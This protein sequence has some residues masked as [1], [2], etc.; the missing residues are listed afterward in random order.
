MPVIHS[1]SHSASSAETSRR[2]DAVFDL[3]HGQRTRLRTTNGLERINREIKRR[4]RVAWIFPNTASCL[5]LVC[6][7]LAECDEEWMT[8]KVYLNWKD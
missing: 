2:Q 5:R 8:G 3:P 7:L 4:T 6:A 1:S